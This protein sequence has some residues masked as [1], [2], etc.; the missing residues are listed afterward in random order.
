VEYRVYRKILAAMGIIGY[1]LQASYGIQ[2]NK[3]ALV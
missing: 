1:E 3:E 2:Q